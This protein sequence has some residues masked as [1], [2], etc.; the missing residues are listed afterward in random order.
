MQHRALLKYFLFLRAHWNL[1]LALFT[2]RHEIS[3]EK[4]YGID[5]LGVDD[6]KNADVKSS[7]KKHAYIYQPASYYLL[8]KS[9]DFL[10]ADF[11]KSGFVDYGCGKGRVMA[12]AA[13]NGYKNISG[14]DFSLPL[15]EVARKNIDKI[16]CFFP[17]SNFKTL[18]MDAT[19]Y[20]IQKEDT[21]FFFFNPFDDV[22]MLQ[23]VKNI[24]AS[25][26]KIPREIV[27]VYL[28]PLFKE[29]FLAAGFEEVY[30]YSKLDYL[31]VS[32]LLK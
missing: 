25:Q 32:I 13:F 6:L 4:K 31:E 14:I 12:V 8:K 18:C 20:E 30:S 28:N 10:N 3:G 24:L 27:I 19:E 16:K 2:I 11:D 29:I 15:C 26:K 7:N 17:T 23:V 9:F 22:V 5:T 1:Q 21:T